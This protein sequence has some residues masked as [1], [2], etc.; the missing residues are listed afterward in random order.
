MV[1]YKITASINKAA[2]GFIEVDN[3]R[4]SNKAEVAR[5]KETKAEKSYTICFNCEHGFSD[6]EVEARILTLGGKVLEQ[7]TPQ[8]VA[9]RRA[10]K[11][12]K[13]KITSLDNVSVDGDEVQF[14]VRCESGTYV[15]ELVHSDEGRTTPSVAGVLEAECK[16]LW[17]DVEDI[18]AD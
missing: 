8:R 7:Q 5:I 4:F 17:L 6:A 10:D 3:L 2:E 15:K 11:I 16:V 14:R 12:R 18:H 9:H 13:R 1:F